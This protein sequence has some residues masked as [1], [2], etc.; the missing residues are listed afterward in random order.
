MLLGYYPIYKDG[1]I[2]TENPFEYNSGKDS[3][4]R[5]GTD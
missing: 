3:G 2:Y 5:K 4:Y 1:E